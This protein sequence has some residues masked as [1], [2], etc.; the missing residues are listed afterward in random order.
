M[1]SGTK[2]SVWAVS[3]WSCYETSLWPW[4]AAAGDLAWSAGEGGAGAAYRRSLHVA[5]AQT[6]RL[7]HE[8]GQVAREEKWPRTAP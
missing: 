6:V 7:E 8:G 2:R 5:G 4:P 1:G 3:G